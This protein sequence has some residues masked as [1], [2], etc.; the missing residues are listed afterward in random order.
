[1]AKDTKWRRNIAENFNRLSRAQYGART[2]QT[3][4]TTDRRQ[5][6]ELHNLTLYGISLRQ[7]N[8]HIAISEIAFIANVNVSSLSR[9]LKTD[10]ILIK[11]LSQMYL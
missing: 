10:R 5:K 7:R 8:G 1:M 6:I 2:L 9:S 11:F 3:S 4:Q